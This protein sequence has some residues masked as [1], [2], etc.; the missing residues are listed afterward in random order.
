MTVLQSH[1]P[2]NGGRRASIECGNQEMIVEM[3]ISTR[4]APAKMEMVK[5][6]V[7]LFVDTNHSAICGGDLKRIETSITVS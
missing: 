4:V 1:A 6:V 7:V 3:T 2:T 5:C